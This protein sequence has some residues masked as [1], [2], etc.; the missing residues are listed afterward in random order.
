[1]KNIYENT[2]IPSWVIG[3]SNE[4]LISHIKYLTHNANRDKKTIAKSRFRYRKAEKELNTIEKKTIARMLSHIEKN[5]TEVGEV[6]EY[7]WKELDKGT[8]FE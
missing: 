1:M 5:L 4:Q 6:E 2:E 3:A 7:L 8:E